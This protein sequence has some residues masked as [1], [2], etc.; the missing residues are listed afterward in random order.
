M[1]ILTVASGG[2]I[3]AA[4]NAA[5]N[6]DTVQVAAGHYIDQFLTY[7]QRHK[8][9]RRRRVRGHDRDPAAA[10]RQSDDR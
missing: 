8:V 2:S 3:Q 4:I 9:G 10:E 7:L 6:G 5:S 1:A